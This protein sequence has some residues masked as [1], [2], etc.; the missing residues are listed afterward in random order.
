[1]PY[2]HEKQVA[3]RAVTAAAQLCEQIRREQNAL[4]ITKPDR[5]PVTIADFGAQAVICQALAAAFPHDPVVGE[6]DSALLQRADM[7]ERLSQV[8]NY[9]KNQ[10]SDANPEAVTAWIDRG[11]GKV[12]PR[13]WTLDPIDGTKGYLRGDQYAIALGLV[14][15]GDLKL[16]I[17]GCPAIPVD[18]TQPD[19]ERGVLFVGVR[20]QGTTVIPLAGGEP[21]QICVSNTSN[22][23]A[24]RLVESV[25]SAH[26][27][28][29][30]QQEVTRL[31]GF[32]APPLRMDS[33]VKYGVIAWG[34][35]ALYLRLPSPLSSP[36]RQNIWD[37]AAGA[38]VLEEA[39]GRVTDM[40][41]RR[42]DFSCGSK[43]VNN[44]GIIA[45]NGAIHEAVLA[46]V[47]QCI[48]AN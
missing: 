23:D 43:L 48:K 29:S 27:N 1:M 25:E 20:N 38:I 11:N 41:G 12:A 42:L 39:G 37:H 28:T 46:T 5:S 4:A 21:R 40:Y 3:I 34:E 30:L 47:K 6:E 15:E 7:T 32:T 9:V 19:G 17:M 18:P 31:L 45:S 44:Q 22:G 26:G 33:M 24:H 13:Y 16:G 8:A 2:Q 10:I 35:A 14:E 36:K